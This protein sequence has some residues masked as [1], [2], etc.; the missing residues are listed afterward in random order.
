MSTGNSKLRAAFEAYLKACERSQGVS[1]C[2]IVTDAVKASTKKLR[3]MR[4]DLA[5]GKKYGS[6]DFG[7]HDSFVEYYEYWIEVERTKLDF[8]KALEEVLEDHN[9][10]ED[11]SA[12][13]EYLRG[14]RNV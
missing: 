7:S 1:M 9:D 4:D 8:L 13:V 12:V 6:L 3:E 2:W 11:L 14:K 10:A 5:Y